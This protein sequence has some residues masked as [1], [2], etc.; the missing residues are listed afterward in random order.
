MTSLTLK[1]IEI[2]ITRSKM[3]N[4]SVKAQVFQILVQSGIDPKVAIKVCNL[5][6]DPEEV[7]IQS[8]PY[9]DAKYTTEVKDIDDKS[10]Q[11]IEQN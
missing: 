9:L 11:N 2:K 1:D 8:K 7:Y 6:S 5:F 3:D 10:N 4:M